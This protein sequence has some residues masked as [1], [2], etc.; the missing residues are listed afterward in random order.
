MS[1]ATAVAQAQMY[2]GANRPKEAIRVLNSGLAEN[3]DDVECLRLLAQAE[4]AASAGPEGGAN[5][6]PAAQRAVELAGQDAFAWR[7]LSICYT[8]LGS[9]QQARDAAR[10][11]RG[12]EPGVWVNHTVV[13]HADATA[14]VITDDTRASVA[15]AMQ[16]APNQP[17][18]HFAAGHVAQMSRKNDLAVQHYQRTLAL[19]P[20]HAGAR[21]NLAL[22]QMR[23]GNAGSAAAA[24]T[25]M[26]AQNPNSELALRN[27]RATG[28]S[29][30]RIIYFALAICVI[31]MN[32]IDSGSGPDTVQQTR[33]A[34]AVVAAIAVLG[35]VGY[36][37]WIRR[38]AGVYFGRFVRSVP[39][40][41]KLLTAWAIILAVCLVTLV[42]AVFTPFIVAAGLYVLTE[43]L[44][45]GTVLIVSIIRSVQRRRSR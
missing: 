32:T 11:A 23:R 19:S 14:R 34:G 22:I 8:R 35:V 9:H 3:P 20:E 37:F 6:L 13:A 24:F 12:L 41:D 40:T 26:L 29:V 18:V 39:A 30:L 33:I 36:V 38:R 25:S 43:W 31:I 44:L 28:F 1:E 5:A 16:L 27:L 7:I 4:L 2:L 21:N 17:E 45:I 15:A 42:A 10:M